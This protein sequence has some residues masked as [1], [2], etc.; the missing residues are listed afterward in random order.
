VKKFSLFLI[1]FLIIQIELHAKP[2][3]INYTNKNI[4]RDILIHND[5][6]W[7]A[8]SGGVANLDIN[9]NMHTSYTTADGLADN[10]VNSIAIDREGNKWF[11]CYDYHDENGGVSKFDGTNW[12][13]Y[14]TTDG[15][16]DNNV[17][18]IVID[19]DG[20]YWFGTGP[21]DGGGISKYDGTNW[22]TYDTSNGLADNVVMAIAIDREG[23]KW[24]GCYDYNDEN[25]GVSKFD[26][27]DWTTYT[28]SDGLASLDSLTDS[29]MTLF[30]ARRISNIIIDEINIIHTELF[31]QWNLRHISI[32]F[33][34]QT[35]ENI[36]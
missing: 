25:G 33:R 2:E 8:T 4:I 6:V 7:L 12:T 35:F 22:T 30:H 24:F 3:F 13:T 18:S 16:A 23:N 15:L 26:G 20:N 32:P 11:G 34:V 36:P 10:I 17:S 29:F 27:T 31:Q 1:L 9:G 5:T 28:E 19:S 21:F 14:K